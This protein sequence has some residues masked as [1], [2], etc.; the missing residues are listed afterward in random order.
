MALEHA[1]WE[2]RGDRDV[3]LAAVAQNG[4]AL[5]YAHSDLQADAEVAHRA[6]VLRSEL[7]NM[8]DTLR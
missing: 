3:V 7:K 2:L 8:K 6:V 1:E 4:L 5:R